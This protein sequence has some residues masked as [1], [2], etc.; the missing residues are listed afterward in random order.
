MAHEN[1]VLWGGGVQSKH[2]YEIRWEVDFADPPNVGLNAEFTIK[3]GMKGCHVAK[4]LETKWNDKPENRD[5]SLA[6][7]CGSTVEFAG[8]VKSMEY[9]VDGSNTTPLPTNHSA[10]E[11]VKG[12]FASLD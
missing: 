6:V 4:V 7:A 11:V 2:K 9:S 3:H 5:T 10:Q 8:E 12:L 1:K